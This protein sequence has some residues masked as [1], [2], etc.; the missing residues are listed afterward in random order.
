M[1]DRCALNAIQ[2]IAAPTLAVTGLELNS[3]LKEGD[4]VISDGGDDDDSWLLG[5]EDIL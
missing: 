4:L 1:G 2:S 5:T 3:R